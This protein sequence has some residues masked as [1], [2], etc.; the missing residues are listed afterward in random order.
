MKNEKVKEDEIESAKVG[1]K[2][3]ERGGGEGRENKRKKKDHQR[4]IK[5]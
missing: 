5:N 3:K 4:Q 1:E 2:K